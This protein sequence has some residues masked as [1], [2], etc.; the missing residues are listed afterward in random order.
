MKSRAPDASTKDR[1]LGLGR[2][3]KVCNGANETIVA[4]TTLQVV[5]NIHKFRPS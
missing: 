1:E 3:E 4:L 2:M 5:D